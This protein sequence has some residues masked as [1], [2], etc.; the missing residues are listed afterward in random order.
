[1]DFANNYTL[2]QI[3]Q[4][5]AH[6]DPQRIAVVFLKD[7]GSE[8]IITAGEFHSR[9]VNYALALE[10]FGIEQDDLIILVLPHSTE[11]LFAFWGQCI[12]VRSARF[13]LLD[14]EA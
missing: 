12:L 10:T 8:E 13:F 14:R 3:I 1:M 4:L 5:R 9:T 7:D 11:L 2:T 6:E